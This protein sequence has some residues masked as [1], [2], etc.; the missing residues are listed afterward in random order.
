MELLCWFFIILDMIA[1]SI[2]CDC[3]DKAINF[4]YADIVVEGFILIARCDRGAPCS[5]DMV[6]LIFASL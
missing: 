6:L 1:I 3:F 2:A 5:M 4:F